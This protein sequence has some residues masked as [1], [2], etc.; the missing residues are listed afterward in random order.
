MAMDTPIWSL[1]H[2]FITRRNH[3]MA[4]L[5]TFT[6]DWMERSDEYRSTSSIQSISFL[7]SFPTIDARYSWGHR[8]I[9]V[10]AS[11]S[12]AYRIWI[13]MESMVNEIL[14]VGARWTLWILVDLAVSAPGEKDDIHT[15]SVYIYFGSR[16]NKLTEY[17]QKIVPSQFLIHLK[18]P[19]PI[20]DFGFSLASQS[21]FSSKAIASSNSTLISD[22]PSLII[23]APKANMIVQLR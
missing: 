20:H 9:H 13:E 4:V 21:P 5:F 3:R 12:C 14:L 17:A 11:L 7:F 16:T 10:S 18:Q 19:I 2:R 6:S 15:G 23:G 22:Y 8:Y 1:A